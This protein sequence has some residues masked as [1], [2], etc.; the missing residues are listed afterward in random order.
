M[1]P[2]NTFSD[3]KHNHS[4]LKRM[5]GSPCHLLELGSSELEEVKGIQLKVSPAQYDSQ[6]CNCLYKSSYDLY[7]SLTQNTAVCQMQNSGVV[8]LGKKTSRLPTA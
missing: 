2:Q 1:L 8:G 5:V 7:T 3:N 6:W 4:S